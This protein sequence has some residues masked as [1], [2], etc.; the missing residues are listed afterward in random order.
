MAIGDMKAK[1][2]PIGGKM[3][4]KVKSI[5]SPAGKQLNGGTSVNVGGGGKR[6]LGGK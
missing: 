2:N 6:S 4:L 3:P 1:V 5:T